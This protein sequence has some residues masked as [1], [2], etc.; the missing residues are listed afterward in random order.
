MSCDWSA[1]AYDGIQGTL[2]WFGGVRMFFHAAA[3]LWATVFFYKTGVDSKSKLMVWS[4]LVLEWVD[5]IFMCVV[6]VLLNHITGGEFIVI[7]TFFFERFQKKKIYVYVVLPKAFT[8]IIRIIKKGGGGVL[9]IFMVV[10]FLPIMFGQAVTSKAMHIHLIVLDSVTHLPLVVTVIIT[11]GF[12]IHWFVFV[13]IAYKLILLLRAYGYHG[14]YQLIVN[15]D[16]VEKQDRAEQ[17][18]VDDDN[19]P[20]TGDKEVKQTDT[21]TDATFAE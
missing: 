20:S 1:S 14:F 10:W 6:I 8:K 11:K 9:T 5:L 21:K 17:K 3:M 15:R 13:D 16:E 4:S 12:K 7:K 19:E 18:I 2:H